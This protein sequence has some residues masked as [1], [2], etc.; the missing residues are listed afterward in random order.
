[1]AGEQIHPRDAIQDLVD[2]RLDPDKRVEVTS[3]IAGCELCR[4]EAEAM[5][6]LKRVLRER[7]S[8]SE[9]PAALKAEWAAALDRETGSASAGGDARGSAANPQPRRR[10][11]QA[12]VAAAAVVVVV[13]VATWMT[14]PLDPSRDVVESLAADFTAIAGTHLT[15]DAPLSDPAGLEAFFVARGVPFP[16]HVYDLAMMDFRLAGG[17]VHR[18]DRRI[19]ALFAYRNGAGDWLVCQ[20]FRGTSSEIP[21]D[22][23]RLA[24]ND[25]EFHVFTRERVTVVVWAEGEVLCALASDL[26]EG[27]VVDLAIAKAM[28]V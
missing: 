17:R 26:P 13:V 12:L 14:K 7:L 24:R 3:H 2:G 21:G 23:R 18:V 22:A 25:I 1:M 16:T 27:A 15:L 19:S 4:R 20:M 9:L 28:K 8:E 10:L 6:G 5:S 11:M